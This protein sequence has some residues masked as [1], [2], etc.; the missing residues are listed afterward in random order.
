MCVIT[1]NIRYFKLLEGRID[2]PYLQS[3]TVYVYSFEQ[4]VIYYTS[5][6]RGTCRCL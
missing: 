1:V 5:N 4:P 6:K 3:Y 2:V